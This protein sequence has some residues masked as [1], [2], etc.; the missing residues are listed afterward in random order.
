[1]PDF[2]GKIYLKTTG[3]AMGTRFAPSFANLYVGDF[4]QY[5]IYG[6]HKWKDNIIYFKR[7]IDGFIFTSD[8]TD[9]EMF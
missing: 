4:K 3:T 8:F 2:N 6:D 5:Y 7:Y 1:M 9:L